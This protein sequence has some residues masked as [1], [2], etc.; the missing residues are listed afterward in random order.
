MG[1]VGGTILRS[2]E[3]VR[4]CG[5]GKEGV[6]GLM[7]ELADDAE[8]S[9]VRDV[10]E[11]ELEVRPRIPRDPESVGDFLAAS[12]RLMFSSRSVR[13]SF[14]GLRASGSQVPFS[15]DCHHALDCLSGA[16]WRST[17]AKLSPTMRAWSS[18]SDRALCSVASSSSAAACRTSVCLLWVE[19]RRP[20]ASILKTI[21]SSSEM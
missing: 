5:G 11:L 8:V 15:R 20:Q 4:E 2:L 21:R 12:S 7:G 17:S 13:T 6:V 1:P 3:A 18:L 10:L 16:A 9:E 14:A 19:S